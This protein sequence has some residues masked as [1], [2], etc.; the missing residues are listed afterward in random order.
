MILTKKK[1]YTGTI[2]KV[3]DDDKTRVLGL[4][5]TV[6]DLLSEGVFDECDVNPEWWAGIHNDDDLRTV[7]GR[8]REELISNWNDAD[9]LEP[10]VIA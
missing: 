6:A 9:A 5:G 7:F 8:T 2:R 10:E 3:W 4:L 1:N